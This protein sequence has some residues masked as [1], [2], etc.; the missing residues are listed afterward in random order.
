MIL[1]MQLVSCEVK[2][3]SCPLLNSWPQLWHSYWQLDYCLLQC[4]HLKVYFH[5]EVSMYLAFTFQPSISGLRTFLN[6]KQIP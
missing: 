2:D 4:Y 3:T 6:H 1:D 5:H